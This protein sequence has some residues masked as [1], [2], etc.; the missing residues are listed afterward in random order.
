MSELLQI[1]YYYGDEPDRLC[2]YRIPKVMFTKAC[3][4]DVSTDAKVLYG[5][6]LDQMSLSVENR[7]ID[8]NNRVFIMFS[9]QRV[10][11]YLGCKKDKALK[12]LAELDVETG[13]G[14]IE[15]VKRGQG[16][17]DVIYVKSFE[18]AADAKDKDEIRNLR[19]N[20]SD[21]RENENIFPE[22][23]DEDYDMKVVGKNDQSENPTTLYI[24]K[25]VGKI[26][27]S[28]K[29][30]SLYEKKV[31]GKTDRSEISTSCGRKNRVLEVGNSDPNNTEYN[32]T[33]NINSNPI[34]LSY[35]SRSSVRKKIQDYNDQRKSDGLIDEYSTYD[36]Q[37]LKI[38]ERNLEYE[39]HM[40]YDSWDDKEMYKELFK[41]IVQTVCIKRDSINI[42]GT[43]Y[44]YEVVKSRFLKLNSNH[45][46]YVM[47]CM[48]KTTTKITNIRAYML[49]ALYNS[50]DT[51]NHYY[52]QEVQHD[53]RRDRDFVSDTE[54]LEKM[55]EKYGGAI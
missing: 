16:K 48:R 50:T 20:I 45:L 30:T 39:N 31:V 5:L 14:L 23:V 43:S 40:K 33:E 27:Q 35:G 49:T 6:L 2:F 55:K 1:D 13:I 32:D 53:M 12:L 15:R 18:V 7:W 36:P 9:V 28:E 3:F 44:P 10:C 37:Y 17:S 24:G 54:Y 41:I 42:N 29:T 51:M 34:N 21:K 47:D 25:Q 8:G 52:Q 19:K 22:D 4:A 46:E 11:A 26:D 38:L